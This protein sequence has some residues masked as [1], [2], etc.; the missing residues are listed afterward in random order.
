MSICS[1]SF[2]FGG[3]PVSVRSE[4]RAKGCGCVGVY[5]FGVRVL[6]V[7]FFVRPRFA[8]QTVFISCRCRSRCSRSQRCQCFIF[9]VANCNC[10]FVF[11]YNELALSCVFNLAARER[12][13]ENLRCEREKVGERVGAASPF[14]LFY[15]PF[16]LSPSLFLSVSF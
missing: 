11:G 8:C 15:L 3:S 16:S 5:F 4:Q 14:S 2:S 9:F 7:F 12:S 13:T 1:T 6:H 10:N